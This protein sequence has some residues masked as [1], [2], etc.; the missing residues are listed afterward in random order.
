MSAAGSPM[1]ALR[2]R[3]AALAARERAL[4]VSA[5]LL[6]ALALLWLIGIQP[7]WRT[8]RA[9]P[10]EQAQLEAQWQTLQRQAAEA[11]TL[12]AAPPL[13]PA[14]AA[15]ALQGATTRLGASGRLM[16]QGERA[17]LTLDGAS[18]DAIAQ[19]LAEA[20]RG[21]RARPVEA[22]LRMD[23]DGYSGS[24]VVSLGGRP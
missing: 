2:A 16:L 19:W 12:R 3:W 4:L 14:L 10:A 24:I 1:A 9:A 6:I 11:R 21:A 15:Q 23:A 17:V 8:L 22:K 20:R 5:A 7:A 18:G 13:A